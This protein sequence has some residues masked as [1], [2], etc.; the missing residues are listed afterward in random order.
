MET[1][2]RNFKIYR[3]DNKEGKLVEKLNYVNGFLD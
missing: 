3:G 1:T 2:K